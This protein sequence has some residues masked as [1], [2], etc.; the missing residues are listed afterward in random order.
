MVMYGR[1]RL[2]ELGTT[3]RVEK[4]LLADG[5]LVVRTPDEG[6][7][8]FAEARA[9]EESE[10]DQALATLRAKGIARPVL[11]CLMDS[12]SVAVR[13]WRALEPVLKARGIPIFATGPASVSYVVPAEVGHELV[14]SVLGKGASE[15]FPAPAWPRS[16]FGVYIGSER[17]TFYESRTFKDAKATEGE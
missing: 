11:F 1:R 3:E 5:T 10:M 16:Y 13:V 15:L 14:E 12:Q 2:A 4:T 6:Q 17:H 7:P 8:Y 9:R